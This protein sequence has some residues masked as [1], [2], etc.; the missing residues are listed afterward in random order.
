MNK[1]YVIEREYLG[2]ISIREFVGII[3]RNH[4]ENNKG[5]QQD[6]TKTVENAL[7]V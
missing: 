5:K 3:I 1:P 6:C 2:V 7:D 4:N